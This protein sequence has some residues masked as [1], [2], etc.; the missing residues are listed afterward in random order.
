[1]QLSDN[2]S[3][4]FQN[5]WDTAKEVLRGRSM[6]LNELTINKIILKISAKVLTSE[7]KRKTKNEE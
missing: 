6:S 3:T 2:E 1:M 7:A 5:V 4:T